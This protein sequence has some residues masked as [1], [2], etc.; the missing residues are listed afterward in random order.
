MKAYLK[1][2]LALAAC[3][4]M[5]FASTAQAKEWYEGGHAPQGQRSA[6]AS[7]RRT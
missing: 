5:A 7:G 3:S 4:I 6:M 2:V 1:G